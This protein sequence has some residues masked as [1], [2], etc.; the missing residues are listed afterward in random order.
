[1]WQFAN[2]ETTSLYTSL[3]EQ[4]E[5]LGYTVKSVTADG[6]L[7]IKRAFYGIPYQ[8]CQVHMERLII[9]GTTQ[10][11]QTEAGVVL[12]ALIRTLHQT[13]ST[14]FNNRLNKYLEKYQ[15]FLNE[16]TTNPITGEKYWTHKEL[17]QAVMALIRFKKYLFTYEQNKKIPKT[18]NSLEGHFSHINE[19]IAIHRGLSKSQKQKVLNT[20]LLASTIAPTK[21]KL[22]YI[23]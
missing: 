13:N 8:M 19:L 11:P 7:G 16:K 22:R 3:R 14:T 2:T 9:K 10:N 12:L 1:M 6:F 4:L 17:R 18:T 20:I 23:L 5:G 21:E 15:Y